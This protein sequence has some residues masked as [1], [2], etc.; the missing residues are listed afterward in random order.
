LSANPYTVPVQFAWDPAKH[1]A[2]LR[3]HGVGFHEAATVLEDSLSTTFPDE[4]HPLEEQR[5]VTIGTSERG[6]RPTRDEARARIL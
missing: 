4:S 3:K 5:F 6:Q 1:A 2:N